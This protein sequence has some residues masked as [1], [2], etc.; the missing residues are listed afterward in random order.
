VRRRPASLVLALVAA[1]L[2]VGLVAAGGLLIVHGRTG[3]GRAV[4][5]A[6]SASAPAAAPTAARSAAGSSPVRVI[7]GGG[8]SGHAAARGADP[9][10]DPGAQVLALV[11]TERVR[12]GC[13]PLT[14]DA[15]LDAAAQTHSA[16][17][18]T[19]HYFDHESPDGDDPGQRITTAGYAWASYGENIATGYRDAGAVMQAWMRSPGHRRN[20]LDCGFRNL[21][22]A[23]AWGDRG[24]YWTQDFAS[25]R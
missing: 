20:I 16:D 21:G 1:V 9:V 23:V 6:A 3:I 13:T 7:T 18:A 8:G 17:M 15:R 19:R 5:V 25:P 4:V 12:A 10:A 14:A 11:N 24:G 22:V 2:A